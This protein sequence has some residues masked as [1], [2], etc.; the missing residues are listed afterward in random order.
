MIDPNTR[1]QAAARPS[2][3]IWHATNS[4][5]WRRFT[6]SPLHDEETVLEQ[7]WQNEVGDV[8]WCVVP[9]FDEP[10]GS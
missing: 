4:L 6:R 3:Q 10:P 7:A 9:T 8:D 1:K 2:A 5:R